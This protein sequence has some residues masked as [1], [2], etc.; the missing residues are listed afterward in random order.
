MIMKHALHEEPAFKI[1]NGCVMHAC[2][3][4]KIQH[5]SICFRVRWH[6]IILEDPNSYEVDSGSQNDSLCAHGK[7]AYA[8]SS[9]CCRNDCSMH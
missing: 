4:S 1:S 6:Q 3:H 8:S 7:T 2:I 9:H 5:Q